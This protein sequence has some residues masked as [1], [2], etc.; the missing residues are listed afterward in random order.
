M[1]K[2]QRGEGKMMVDEGEET[3]RK[4]HNVSK[5]DEQEKARLRKMKV[6]GDRR[7][8]GKEKNIIKGVVEL[9]GGSVGKR[10]A[11]RWRKKEKNEERKE[12]GMKSGEE[13]G[14]GKWKMGEGRSKRG[15]KDRKE[16]GR[17]RS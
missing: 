13:G 4:E 16:E 5:V 14:D 1:E 12:R 17:N 8:K 7:E 9:W 15:E 3:K 11:G 10:E 2:R 6:E